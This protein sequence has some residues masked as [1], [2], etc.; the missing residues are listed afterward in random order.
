MVKMGDQIPSPKKISMNKSLKHWLNTTA[1]VFLGSAYSHAALADVF[2]ANAGL[3]TGH[4]IDGY[5][6]TDEKPIVFL[7]GD[8][9]FDNGAFT[10]AECY[11]S[12]SDEG[13]SLSRGCHF[14]A[15]FFAKI[16]ETQALTFELRRKEYLVQGD[17]FW[18][19]FEGAIDWHFNKNVNFSL[20]ATNNWVDQ[21]FATVSVGADYSKPLTDNFTAYALVDVMKFESAA[22]IGYTE[23]YELGVKYQKERWSAGLSAI[24]ADTEL[25][26]L[27]GFD[28]SQNQVRLTVSYRLY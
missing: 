13:E 9:S 12:S 4:F 28:A 6:V 7:G 14:F 1:V 22:D 11:Q 2:Q 15:G 10:G 25:R 27:L 26:D 20:T 8:W 16:N 3:S 23:H 18:R 24:F 19:Y 5:N 21:G 17:M